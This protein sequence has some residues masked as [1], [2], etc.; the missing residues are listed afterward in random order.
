LLK[1][2]GPSANLTDQLDALGKLMEMASKMDG[3]GNDGP[4]WLEGLKLAAPVIQQALAAPRPSGGVPPVAAP[5]PA[6]LVKPPV[7]PSAALPVVVEGRATV[8]EPPPPNPLLA[9]LDELM[10]I[11]VRRARAGG[12]TQ[13][14]VALIVDTI[15]EADG[16]GHFTDAG[17]AQLDALEQALA[18][19]GILDQLAV[20]YPAIVTHRDWFELLL[21]DV[22]AELAFA[23]DDTPDESPPPRELTNDEIDRAVKAAD[24]KA[25]GA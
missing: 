18:L 13:P 4:A 3:K 20:R 24:R 16:E 8:A 7:A 2:A 9:Q 1:P 14:S 22:K 12:P 10:P 25:N 11:V 6:P 21:V 5:A 17:E 15:G 23:R 19:P